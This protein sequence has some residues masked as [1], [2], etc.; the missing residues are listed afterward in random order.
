[1]EFAAAIPDGDELDVRLFSD[2]PRSLIAPVPASDRARADWARRFAKLQTPSGQF[3][4]LGKAANAALK[5]IRSAPPNRLQFIFFITDGEQSAAAASPFPDSWGGDWPTL[6]AEA[7][8]LISAR[9]VSVVV[10]R[11]T[12][13]ADRSM[14]TRVFPGAIVT[15]AIGPEALRVWF[16]R[17]A[18]DVAVEK[19]RL[20]ISR[21]LAQRAYT[22]TGALT[23]DLRGTGSGGAHA[24]LDRSVLTTVF[25]DSA[26]GAFG[27]D[28]MITA[29]SIAPV[30]AGASGVRLRLR[31]PSRAWYL[32]PV[33]ARDSVIVT[34]VGQATLEPAVELSRIG[35]G[36]G[37]RMDSVSFVVTARASMV[38]VLTYYGILAA[39]VVLVIAVIVRGK[40][41]L[42]HAYLDGHLTIETANG[43][44]NS[45]RVE[46]TGKRKQSYTVTTSAGQPVVTFAAVSR[47]GK[48]IVSAIPS[49]GS[50]LLRGKPVS[51]ST[52]LTGTAR[53]EHPD[54][55][56]H[57]FPT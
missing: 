2:A 54:V 9:P 5:E 48:T 8:T 53:I 33:Y 29:T 10:L 42:H 19:L 44:P 50:L 26:T 36:S 52:Q 3:T 23:T 4:D 20:L 17:S 51:G 27:D 16:A 25:V 12:K 49:S 22:V 43:V 45:E 21:E 11:L 41:A 7:S 14:L 55:I 32:P 46:L 15:D 56:V 24:T 37:S 6:A 34:G 38:A 39:L 31:M 35:I 28:G 40:W 57:F 18:R 13:D 47:R 1:L 30:S